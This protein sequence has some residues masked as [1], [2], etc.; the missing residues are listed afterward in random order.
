[1]RRYVMGGAMLVIGATLISKMVRR[2]RFKK[3][4]LEHVSQTEASYRNAR[5]RIL[6][7]GA[8]FGGLAT[9]LT[10]D[11]RMKHVPECSVLVVERD[12]DMLFTPLLWT[13]ANG[14]TSPDNVVA[15]IRDFQKGLFGKRPIFLLIYSRPSS[16]FKGWRR[17]D[18]SC[19]SAAAS[20]FTPWGMASS[21]VPA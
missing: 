3:K 1:M 16:P 14:R 6:I 7:L 9:A 4:S 18:Q 11:Q 15:P 5:T 8:G 10:L 19:L 12:N 13:L 20:R 21:S 2:N 17:S